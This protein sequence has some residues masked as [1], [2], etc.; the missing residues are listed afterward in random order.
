MRGDRV[1]TLGAFVLPTVIYRDVWE[2]GKTYERGDQVTCGGSSWIAKEQTSAKP[3]DPG[4]ASRAWQLAVKAGRE[5]KEGRPGPAGP[6]GPKG[7]KGG[8]AA[9]QW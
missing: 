3:G 9:Q 4:V 2:D 1:K 6:Q 7:D 5:G 8:P